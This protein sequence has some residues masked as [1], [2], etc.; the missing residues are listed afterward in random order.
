MGRHKKNCE[1]DKCKAKRINL[2]ANK[3][4]VKDAEQQEASMNDETP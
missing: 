2:E 4:A 3:E 1:C